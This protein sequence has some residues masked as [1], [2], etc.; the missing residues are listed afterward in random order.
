MLSIIR[1]DTAE[2]ELAERA[3]RWDVFVCE[4]N[5]PFVLEID[6]R[7]LRPDVEHFV[8][9]DPARPDYA[10]G[11]VRLIPDGARSPDGTSNGSTAPSTHPR[12]HY[13]L[14]RL[15]V[16]QEARGTGLGAALVNTI[17]EWVAHATP[18]GSEAVVIL[19]AQLQAQGF[20][21]KCGYRATER[22]T[23][24]DAGIWHREM[25]TVIAGRGD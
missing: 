4:Q 18:S 8:A 14:G 9:I 15:A 10:L 13:H 16:R 12:A 6:A 5:V 20:Y 21:E 25:S 19:D 1:V 24:L 22:E 7:D 17:H 11:C 3:V 2:L 23:F